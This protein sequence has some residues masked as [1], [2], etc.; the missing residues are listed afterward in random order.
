MIGFVNT[1]HPMAAAT[2]SD[3]KAA[4]ATGA[5]ATGPVAPGPSKDAP[6]L[7]VIDYAKALDQCCDGMCACVDPLSRPTDQSIDSFDFIW[8]WF[9]SAVMMCVADAG[10]LA[11]LLVVRSYSAFC[12][13]PCTTLYLNSERGLTAYIVCGSLSSTQD[14]LNESE[15]KL[16]TIKTALKTNDH[17]VITAHSTPSHCTR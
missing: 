6:T 3:G 17:K 4:P 15:S 13:L 1:I 10:F 9:A 14:V 7:S 5:A 8:C 2:A 11:E 16:N 12:I